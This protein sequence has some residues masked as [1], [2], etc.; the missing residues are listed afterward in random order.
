MNGDERAPKVSPLPDPRF[1]RSLEYG[2]ALLE[3]FDRDHPTLGVSELADILRIGRST[4]HRYA[5]TLV[6]HG[7]LEQ[8]ERRRYRLS[9]HA[10]RLGM[11]AIDTVRLE[12]PAV[13]TILENLRD[14]TGHTVSMGVLDGAR[15]IYTHR[16]FAHGA[17]Q[18]G[19][20]LGLRVG[21]HVPLHCTAIGKVLLANLGEPEQHEL[22]A[23]LTL[24]REGPNTIMSKDALAAELA[25]IRAE[26]AA[27]CD[28][29][30]ARGVRSIAAAISHSGRSRPIAVS[31]TAAA[32]QHT[33]KTLTAVLGQHVEAAAEYVAS[34]V[35]GGD[36]GQGVSGRPG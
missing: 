35:R 30:Q 21:A 32:N 6:V 15:V 22:L 20:D 33:V 29:E 17:G 14:Q 10:A 5:A 1:S 31:V 8:D 3:S 18:Y 4:T 23:R 28:E 13:A 12:I 26:G 27:V 16:L 7:A 25:R 2:L 24:K 9:H 36:V 19:A 11:A 34:E